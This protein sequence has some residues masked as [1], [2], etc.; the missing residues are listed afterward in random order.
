MGGDGFPF[1]QT[2][3]QIAC[4]I[5]NNSNVKVWPY[6]LEF[7]EDG[8]VTQRYP[9]TGG[10]EGLAAG[11]STREVAKMKLGVSTENAFQL[12]EYGALN[13]KAKEGNCRGRVTEVLK[14]FASTER[15]DLSLLLQTQFVLREDSCGLSS[16]LRKGD[17]LDEDDVLAWETVNAPFVLEFDM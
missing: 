17:M 5:R 12:A 16:L 11:S 14:L 9:G 8:S 3:D 6:V 7:A 15:I 10:E 2:S 4:V 13:L 1:F